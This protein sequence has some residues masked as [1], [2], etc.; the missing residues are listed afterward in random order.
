MSVV[1]IN[2][3]NKP[4]E[5]FCENGKEENLIALASKIND[6]INQIKKEMPS[7]GPE[8]SFVIAILMM[9]DYIEELENKIK[10]NTGQNNDSTNAIPHEQQQFLTEL[11]KIEKTLEM[12]VSSGE[13]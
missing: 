7:A 3:N 11:D 5:I 1:K 4:Y 8:R 9:A 2:I 6:R 13:N 10:S 12:L